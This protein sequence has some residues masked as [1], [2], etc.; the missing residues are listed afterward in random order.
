MG[1]HSPPPRKSGATKPFVILREALADREDPGIRMLRAQ[2]AIQNGS[3]L[4]VDLRL[5]YRWILTPWLAPELR[6]T[7]DLK[8]GHDG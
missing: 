4:R 5:R 7:E 1:N 2:R 6:M 8:G 3:N